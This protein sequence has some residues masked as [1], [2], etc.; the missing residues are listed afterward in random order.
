MTTGK[1]GMIAGRP[2]VSPIVRLFSFLADKEDVEIVVRVGERSWSLVE[3]ASAE[4]PLPP[5]AAAVPQPA[6]EEERMVE[7]PLIRLAVARSGDKGN[8][9]NIGVMARKADYLPYIRAALT[10]AAV[11]RA[12]AHFVQG[13]VERFDLPGLNALNFLLRDSLGGGGTSSVN[14]DTQGKTYAQLLLSLPVAVPQRWSNEL[15]NKPEPDR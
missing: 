4:A 3:S 10:P 11:R 15:A 2:A 8:D 9:A 7:V 14:L 1:C 5:P 6:L 12:F 13:D